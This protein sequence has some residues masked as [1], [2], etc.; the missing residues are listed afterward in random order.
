MNN[1]TNR[2]L[3]YG[4]SGGVASVVFSIAMY[5]VDP[6]MFVG[7]MVYWVSTGILILFVILTMLHSKSGE[8]ELADFKGLLRSGFVVYIVGNLLC[9]IFL[10]VMF[11]YVDP[12]LQEI[13]RA[14]T[15]EFI[16][17]FKGGDETSEEIINALNYDYSMTIG[18]TIFS[19][20]QGLIFGFLVAAGLGYMMKEKPY[21]EQ[22]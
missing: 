21:F 2:D 12:D 16:T 8:R 14:Q 17:K 7:S 13:Q 20:F 19:Y 18:G 5:M 4:I 22:N 11:N 10:F 3:I 1:N 9:Y 15:V 6:K